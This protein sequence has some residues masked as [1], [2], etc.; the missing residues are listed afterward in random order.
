[1]DTGSDE[2]AQ[3]GLIYE[4]RR[5]F[6]DFHFRQQRW[7]ILVC[8]RRAGKTVACVAELVM[9]AELARINGLRDA[10]FAY[11]GPHLNQVKD[12]AWMY[13]KRLTAH[14]GAEYNEAELRVD[15]PW[16]AR[17][18][19]YGADNPDRL[20]G[21]Y[22]DGVIMDEFADMR[23]SV[24]GEIVRPMLA[25]RK[26]WAVFIGTPKGHNEFYRLWKTTSGQPDWYRLML[27]ASESGMLSPQELADAERGMSED[28]YAQEF[29]CSFEAAIA[30]SILG[31]EIEKAEKDG[32]VGDHIV[33]DPDG[34]CV[35]ISSDIG[36][37]D[38]AAW[39]FWQ[40]AVGGFRIIDF[41]AAS[42]LDADDWCER[43]KARVSGLGAT[44]G[45]IYLPHDARAK[46]FQSKHSAV[47]R[48]LGQFGAE[49]CSIVPQ[50]RI[51]D[52]VN[53]ARRVITRCSFSLP[54]CE[55]GLDALRSWQFEWNEET[56]SFG[57]DPKHDFASHPGDAFSYGCQVLEEKLPPESKKATDWL[58]IPP[59]T[60]DEVLRDHERQLSRRQRI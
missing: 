18:R 35:H 26:G 28:Q 17:I 30:G 51:A 31:R 47:E 22:L 24:F 23:D 38:T 10:R 6:E 50:S 40:P 8:H 54:A 16:G 42:G 32:R 3:R 49:H 46:T 7:A 41:D 13:V 56:R 33:Y 1:M 5:P 29:E 58:N 34:A 39:W 14:Y 4:P 52:R 25:D 19:L 21:L 20:R 36:F 37:R 15:F 9:A 12:V 53:A 43:I 57:K 44:L 59:E 55:W 27:R 11:I 45:T 48:F 60:Y 2:A